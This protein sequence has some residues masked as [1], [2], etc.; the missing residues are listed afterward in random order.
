MSHSG[1]RQRPDVSE[2]I[3][4]LQPDRTLA[5]RGFDGFAS[6][7]AIHNASSTGFRVS[8]TFRD[9][10]DFAVAVLYDADNTY[11][12]PRVRYLPDFDFSG[13]ALSF[14][15]HY[16]AGLQPI[17]SPRFNW[18]DWATLDCIRA[19]GSTAKVRLW[20]HAMLASP[21]F[22]AA[23]AVINVSTDSQIEAYD[24]LTLWYQNLA[25]DYIVPEGKTAVE[26][27]FFAQGTGTTHSISVNGRAY[28]YT[29]T[30]PLG[31][32]SAQQAA[33][34]INAMS[35]DPDVTASAGSQAHKV[36]LT[37]RASSAGQAIA[38]SAS[39]GNGGE[40]MRYTT[41]L[42]VAAALTDAINGTN[43]IAA[44]TPHALLAE[45]S[46]AHITLTAGRYG[47]VNLSGT[48]VSWVSGAPFSG[49]TVGSLIR[50]A[51]IYATVASIESPTHVT[52]TASA[53]SA[54]GV[55]YV[56]SRGG[57]DGNLIQLTTLSKNSRLTFDQSV[58]QLSGGQSDV[59]WNINID[60]SA[61]GIPQLRQC[62]LT[63]A[64]AL[65]P[66]AFSSNEWQA[67]FSNW[68]LTGAEN[69]KT[70]QVAGPGS[71]RVES[72]STACTYAG[73]WNRESGFYSKYFAQA[74]ADPAASVTVTYNCQATH[75]LYL[76]TSLYSDRAI[77]GITLD[78]DTETSL[79]CRLTTGSAIVTRRLL[80]SA[81]APGK[82]SVTVRIQQAGVLY[83]DFLEAAVRSAIPTPLA[84]RNNISPAL[85][86]DT[87][88]TYKLP[89]SRLLWAFDQLGYA[90]AIN[91]YLGVFWWNERTR[92]GGSVSSAEVTFSGAFAGG[93]S[94]FL[95]LNGSTLGKSVFPADTP[96]TIASHFA[97][98]INAT[99]VGA[100]ASSSGN[101]LTVT[102]RSAAASWELT[103]SVS[104][105]STSGAATVTRQPVAGNQGVWV[106]DDAARPAWN[107]ATREWHADFYAQCAARNREVTTACSMELV[108]PPAGCVSR[109]ADAARTPVSTDTGFGSLKS[110][111]GAIGS[112]RVLAW[113]KAVYRAIAQLQQEAGLTPSV[114]YGEFLWW[115][116]SGPGGMGYYDDETMAAAQAALGRPL[117]VFQTPDDDPALHPADALFL[118]NRL[119]DHLTYL[120]TD[121]RSAYPTAKCELLWPY[122]VNHPAPVPATSP[123]LGGRLNRYINLPVEW[124]QPA[125]SGFDRVKVE[126][127]AFGSAM[128]DM[129]LASDA[130][131][132][133]RDF[134]WSP[135]ALA[136]LVPVFGIATPWQ[137][138]VAL[139]IGAG[140]PLIN[141]WA[142]DHVCLYNLAVPEPKLDARSFA[143]TA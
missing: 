135:G 106:I 132:L 118:R 82:H 50:I 97:A 55:P 107:R 70:L 96:S 57:N 72:D 38:V 62:W 116:F 120:V 5:L 17:D 74:T 71:V 65:F 85:D 11:E 58:F 139:A 88:H 124:Q 111:H 108:N 87:D 94:V 122:D 53:G 42:L 54:S 131:H 98:Y 40:V 48:S 33:A 28:L 21:S 119:R 14:N 41:P 44:N 125:T 66:G 32:S 143:S 133:F 56:A 95:N 59:T 15:L 52:L 103:V 10:A 4:K 51:N 43:W 13:L 9:P 36:L 2:T 16:A 6:A 126:A 35:S 78:G 60:F 86:F 99:F 31:E 112:A 136:Y 104:A 77:A 109:F 115:Y 90:G 18:I 69:K 19:D 102:S 27:A 137:R 34:L 39:D 110:Q 130:I 93:D 3:Y 114:Q 128:R 1:R 121:L 8:G 23:S 7:A 89:P 64:P 47:T 117:Y 123:Y 101:V 75:D 129:N 29:E 63:F 141:L 100:W 81:V 49:I 25:F 67:Q 76:G 142:W 138:E 134:G 12:H 46:G 80:R 68:Q 24:R 105:T 79:D 37:V 83:F 140:I 22:P 30:D 20:D 73:L 127:L 113:Q 91:E 92:V 61:L 26:F 45:A 84:A